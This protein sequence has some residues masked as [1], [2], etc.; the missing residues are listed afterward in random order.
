MKK[1]TILL[2]R[3]AIGVDMLGHG[4]VRI[5]KLSKFAEGLEHK[6]LSSVIPGGW[7]HFLGYI[8]P[9]FELFLGIL[10][11]L[12]LFRK[13]ASLAG[14]ILMLV[15]L[16]GTCMISRFDL[17]PTQLIHLAFFALVLQFYRKD[18]IALDRVFK[19]TA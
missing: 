7:V 10:L 17:L 12:G 15:F 4:L 19:V 16:F 3:L 18:G 2:F 6:F 14:A 11:I 13:V 1:L 9:F 5:P 8:I